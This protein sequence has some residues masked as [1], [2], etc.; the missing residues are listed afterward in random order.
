MKHTLVAK[1][2]ATGD[3]VRTT[4]LLHRLSGGVTWLTAVKNTAFAHNLQQR[5]R[6]FSWDQRHEAR[7]RE[8]D[9]VINLEDT[10]DVARFLQTVRHKQLFGAYVDS[11]QTLG[12]TRDS[13]GWFDL[14]L[15]SVHGRQQADRLK[16]LN[17]N[18][19]K[20]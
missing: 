20:T 18:T 2:G 11:T 9:L 1:L 8:Y 16:L 17:R 3:V 15:L 4:T 10:L 12:Y 13:R 6:C 5:V 19:Y 14:S 7:D